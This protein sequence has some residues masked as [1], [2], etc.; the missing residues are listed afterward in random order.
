MRDRLFA[1]PR[2]LNWA[3]SKVGT[4]AKPPTELAGGFGLIAYC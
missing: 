1:T 3:E 2:R 4:K